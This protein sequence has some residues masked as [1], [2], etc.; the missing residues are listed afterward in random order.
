MIGEDLLQMMINSFYFLLSILIDIINGG[1]S[2]FFLNQL[3]YVS[4]IQTVLIQICIRKAQHS[5][6]K[7]KSINIPCST[8]FVKF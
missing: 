1:C 5:T 3:L 2:I 4:V 7:E 8:G 6:E